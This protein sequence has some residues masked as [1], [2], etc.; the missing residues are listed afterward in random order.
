MQGF[1]LVKLVSLQ[2]VEEYIYE[3]SVITPQLKFLNIH[4]YLLPLLLILCFPFP[5]YPVLWSQWLHL[6]SSSGGP[7]RQAAISQALCVCNRF[8]FLCTT[9]LY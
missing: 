9:L 6:G 2:E 7:L 1:L 8:V 4:F 5:C 3:V